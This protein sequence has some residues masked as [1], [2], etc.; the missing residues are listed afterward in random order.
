MSKDNK[1]LLGDMFTDLI[2]DLLKRIKDGTATPTDRNVARQMLKDNGIDCTV[3][4]SKPLM[5]LANL[6]PKFD[7]TTD[8]PLPS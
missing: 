5:D 7:Q 1:A 2:V 3:R 6:L 8:P 4:A